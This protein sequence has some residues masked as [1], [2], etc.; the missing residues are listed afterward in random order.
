MAGGTNAAFTLVE[1]LI[2]VGLLAFMMLSLYMA[3]AMGFSMIQTT[4]EDLRATQ[5]VTQK[6]EAIRLCTWQQL[7]NCPATFKD[8]Y[9]PLGVTNGTQGAVYYGTISTTGTYSNLSSTSY[10]SQVHLITMGVTWTNYIS[11]GPIPHSRQMQTL[12][13]Y[14]GLQNYVWGQ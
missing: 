12:S 13:A 10:Q 2:S 1:I 7:S 9:N 5:I 8:Y 3:F 4:R 11:A 14:H 6:L